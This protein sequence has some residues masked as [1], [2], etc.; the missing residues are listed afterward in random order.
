MIRKKILISAPYMHREKEKIEKMLENFSF[1]VDWASVDERLEESD[2]LPIISKYDGILCGDDRITAKVIDAATNLKAIVKWGTGI[3]S[4]N[5]EYAE[6]K[7]IPVF[8]TPNAFTE[9]VADSALALMLNEV[10]GIARNDKVVKE[11]KWEKPQGYTL[12]ER[13]IGI[14]GFGDIGQAVARRLLPFGPKILVNDIKLLNE[15]LIASLCVVSATKEEIYEACDIITLHCD[16]NSTSEHLLNETSFSLMGKKPYI[17]NTARGPLIKE[18]ALIEA[19]KTGLIS[20]VGIDVFE[21]EPL[22]LDNFLRSSELVTGSCH[23]T[24]SSPSCWDHVHIN[25]LTMMDEV[26]K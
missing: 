1:D 20:G 10:R 23:A 25:S 9:P 22:P 4:I 7:G 17:I 14:I 21:H 8:R 13:T 18:A 16:L 11:G 5:K 24:N 15:E 19:L 3:D 2:L 12:G 26:L 6:E